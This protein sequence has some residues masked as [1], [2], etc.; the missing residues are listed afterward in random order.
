MLLVL[1]VP[2]YGTAAEE[3]LLD[4]EAMDSLKK[5]VA[6][7]EGLDS[8]EIHGKAVY[9]VVQED[10]L[11]LQFEKSTRLIQQ[12]PDKL[13]VERLRDNGDVRKFWYDGSNVSILSVDRN[14]YAKLRAPDSID[15]M[16]DMFEGL[17]REPNPLADLLYSDLGH[18]RDL[19]DEAFYVGP[20]TVGSF[21]CDHLSFRNANIDWQLWVQKGETPYIRKVVITY[22]NQ[23]GIP[24]FVSYLQRWVVPGQINKD[25]FLFTPPENAERLS[26]MVPPVV[27]AEE[28]GQP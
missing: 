20:S 3:S 2:A 7:L 19:P 13:Y 15:E 16:L 17:F 12:R 21:V 9:D 27:Y 14:A 18:L 1:C 8:F 26:I 11:R 23:P 22:S 10:G 5:A 4:T 25:T 24:Q 6:F 28:G